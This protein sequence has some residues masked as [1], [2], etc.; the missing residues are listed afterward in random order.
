VWVAVFAADLFAAVRGLDRRDFVAG[1]LLLG[2]V[3]AYLLSH[4]LVHRHHQGRA[5]KELCV[6][7]LLAAGV[8]VF[9][10]VRAPAAAASCGAP[11][12]LFGL[13][14]FTN[15]ALISVWEDEVD[16]S[17]GQTSFAR[18][19]R[20]GRT[21]S[22]ALP[23]LAAAC[24]LGLGARWRGPEAAPAGCALAS[25]LLLVAVDRAERRLGRERARVLADVA[26][27]TPLIPLLGALGR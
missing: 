6:A 20:R 25:G 3:A 14:C 18:Q 11:L 15:C 24:A 13:L 17:H 22:H 9:P 16:R 23:W 2:P 8:G 4:Q 12:A 1:L 19:F 10:A 21:L 26:L 27:M 5:P 7:L